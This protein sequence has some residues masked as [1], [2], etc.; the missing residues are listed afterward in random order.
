[1]MENLHLPLDFLAEETMV[2]GEKLTKSKLENPES[3]DIRDAI[4]EEES[5]PIQL[6]LC[7]NSTES[8]A[9]LS[10]P[11]PD[12]E[13]L[14]HIKERMK[15]YLAND[16]YIQFDEEVENSSSAPQFKIPESP[17]LIYRICESAGTYIVRSVY[18]DDI[19]REM[20]LIH[21][22]YTDQNYAKLRIDEEA[23]LQNLRFFQSETIEQ[24]EVL[25]ELF[26]NRRLPKEEDVLCNISD[27]GFS[28]WLDVQPGKCT[29][30]FKS[31]GVECAQNYLKLGPL[32]DINVF[33]RRMRQLNEI[34]QAH[35]CGM[36]IIEDDN[37]LNINV[38]KG[39]SVFFDALQKLILK[40]ELPEDSELVGVLFRHL[41]LRF[42]LKEVA[43]V[44]TFWLEIESVLNANQLV[45]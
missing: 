21:K 4:G 29:I 12:N 14:K 38:T 8:T 44:R 3:L 39:S 23:E 43:I 28:W 35:S 31:H 2:L 1:M 41:T 40:G 33:R 9:E 25:H 7:S 42:F 32:S 26:S 36:S 10:Q 19:S 18:V 6:D 13:K 30:Y 17:G 27:P 5:G 45:Q 24:A 15:Q 16:S 22:D 34:L 20:K 11:D 37:S